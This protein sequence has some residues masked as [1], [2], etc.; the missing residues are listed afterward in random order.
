MELVSNPVVFKSLWP[1]LLRSYVLDSRRFRK[2]TSER[3]DTPSEHAHEV[4]SEVINATWNEF[5]GVGVGTDLRLNYDGATGS[6]LEYEGNIVHMSVMNDR[7][8]V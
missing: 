6:V 7:I 2:R 8:K 3:S 1:R 4:I 5:P